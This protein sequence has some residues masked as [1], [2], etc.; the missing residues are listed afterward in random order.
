ML[1]PRAEHVVG[2][3]CKQ[4]DVRMGLLAEVRGS[5]K[6]ACPLYFIPGGCLLE[7]TRVLLSS[8]ALG[9]AEKLNFPLSN[10]LGA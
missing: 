7:L 3:K 6:V 8:C 5:D 1:W 2:L 4:P 10:Y 9:F